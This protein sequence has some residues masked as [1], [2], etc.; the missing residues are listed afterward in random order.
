M[1]T[2]EVACSCEEATENIAFSCDTCNKINEIEHLVEKIYCTCD[3]DNPQH[4]IIMK[5]LPGEGTICNMIY[6]GDPCFFCVGKKYG[7]SD[8]ERYDANRMYTSLLKDKKEEMK[9]A[10]FQHWEAGSDTKE[11]FARYEADIP[12]IQC[13]PE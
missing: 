12:I 1:E 10:L 4:I 13:M 2:E 11:I 9:N 7:I 6:C 8:Q 3:I 5:S